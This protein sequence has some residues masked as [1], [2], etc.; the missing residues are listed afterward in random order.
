MRAENKLLAEKY[1]AIHL[2]PPHMLA[3]IGAWQLDIA[4]VCIGIGYFLSALFNA[5]VC[6]PV[7]AYMY[8]ASI[9]S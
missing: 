9:K 7:C 6:G 8:L 5:T 3:F 2:R 4:T 1:P